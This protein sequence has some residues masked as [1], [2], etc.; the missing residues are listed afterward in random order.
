ML[1]AFASFHILAVIEW[2]FISLFRYEGIP[3]EW[4][5]P[6]RKDYSDHVSIFPICKDYSDHIDMSSLMF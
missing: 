2:I 1:K 6:K 5:P 3:D 4:E